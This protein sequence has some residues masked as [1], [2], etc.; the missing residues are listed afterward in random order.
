MSWDHSRLIDVG[1]PWRV[2]IIHEHDI[3]LTDF[4]NRMSLHRSSSIRCATLRVSSHLGRSCSWAC[5][6]LSRLAPERHTTSEDG[7]TPA[8]S[9]TEVERQNNAEGSEDDRRRRR[10][11]RASRRGTDNVNALLTSRATA[12]TT[13]DPLLHA[14]ALNNY[15]VLFVI[16]VHKRTYAPS[17]TLDVSSS[18]QMSAKTASSRVRES[19]VP[20]K[21]GAQTPRRPARD[22]QCV[23]LYRLYRQDG[24]SMAVPPAR[25]PA[26]ANGL[27]L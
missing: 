22:P 13:N 21:N 16:A 12:R 10:H 4:L 20:C 1:R 9:M 2:H 18:L 11:G 27:H 3:R 17:S 26:L 25:V 5:P 14:E 23:L 7:G 6:I 8:L 24:L 15:V 19:P